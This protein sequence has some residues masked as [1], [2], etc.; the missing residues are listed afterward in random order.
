MTLVQQT[1]GLLERVLRTHPHDTGLVSEVEA[2]YSRVFNEATHA[3]SAS[4]SG[5]GVSDSKEG[6]GTG[7]SDKSTAVQPS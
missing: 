6:D 1:K 4:T 2:L 3:D 7:D 5:G